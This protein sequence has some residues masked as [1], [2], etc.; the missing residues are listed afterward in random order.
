MFHVL[1]VPTTSTKPQPTLCGQ[2]DSV[3][4]TFSRRCAPKKILCYRALSV[5]LQPLKLPHQPPP[6]P[7]LATSLYLCGAHR[8]IHTHTH[9]QYTFATGGRRSQPECITSH[10]H[11]VHRSLYAQFAGGC[12]VNVL[13]APVIVAHEHRAF[14]PCIV[15]NS[16]YER[17]A[18]PF[19]ATL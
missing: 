12:L 9:T 5:A 18:R 4:G 11:T 16:A 19:G 3:S 2:Y 13:W 8:A 15:L 7:T 14:A 17:G 1:K 10:T 6:E